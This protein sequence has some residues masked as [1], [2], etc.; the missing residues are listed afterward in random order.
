MPPQVED[1][2][3]C[4]REVAVM[5]YQDGAMTAKALEERLPRELSNSALRAM[6]F[7]LLRKGILTRRKLTGSHLSTDRRI[8]YVYF[9]AITPEATRRAVLRQIARDYFDGSLLAVAKATIEALNDEI[10]ADPARAEEFGTRSAAR[11]HIAA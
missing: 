11:L 10:A 8:P 3:R 4:E 5:I 6:L 2:P 7:R 1:L 9:P